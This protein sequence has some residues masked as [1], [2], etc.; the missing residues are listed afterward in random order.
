[1]V[2][3]SFRMLI[4]DKFRFFITVS[5]VAFAVSLILVQI[6]LFIGILD[7]ATVTIEHLPADLWI[8]SKNSPNLDFV[9]QF[10]EMSVSRVRATPGV[11][12]ADNLILAFMTV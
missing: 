11:R 1:M 12:R 6:G 9:H 4:H 3:L 8:T 2:D 7:N 10:S 5:G